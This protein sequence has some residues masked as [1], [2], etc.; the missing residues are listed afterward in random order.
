MKIKWYVSVSRKREEKGFCYSLNETVSLYKGKA[1][2]YI[3]QA[4]QLEVTENRITER[5]TEKIYEIYLYHGK[6]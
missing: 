3:T 1:W 2:P 6:S 4:K 5:K